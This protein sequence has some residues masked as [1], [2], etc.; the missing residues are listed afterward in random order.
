MNAR[1]RPI[2]P[3]LV[4]LFVWLA[5]VTQWRTL[6][7]P[8]PVAH[9]AQGDLLREV[10]VPA[11]AQCSSGIGTSVAIVPGST[12]NRPQHPILLVVSCYNSQTSSLY[13][14][15]PSTNPAT[16]VLT[17][18]TSPTPTS[19]WGS[20]SFRGDEGDLLGCGNGAT[21]PIYAI[22]IN[23]SNVPAD[24]T[25]TFLF[26]ATA[27]LN[28]CD[29]VAWDTSDNT[30]FQGPDVSNTIY[31]YTAAGASLGSLVSP[32]PYD[33]GQS[34]YKGKSGL[35]V[36]G[37]SLFIACD[38]SLLIYEVNKTTGATITSFNTAGT[39][40]EDLEC[41]PLTFSGE[42]KD[43]IWSR[44]AYTNQLFA[45]EIPLDTCGF[46]G[47]LPGQISLEKTV[48]LDAGTCATGDSLIVSVTT[49]VT[50][51]YRV[52]NTGPL[53]MTTH[54]LVDSKVGT[55]LNDFNYVLA[56]GASTFVT[57]TAVITR[58]TVNTATWT[59]YTADGNPATASD[60]ATVDAYRIF[61][62]LVLGGA[63]I[64]AAAGW[65]RRE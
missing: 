18:T 10:D 21:A 11:G 17:I 47:G 7:Q 56:P 22:D 37:T 16:L 6:W 9:A 26:N 53:T 62:P 57:A 15:A 12:V 59:A 64:T 14:L 43:A 2:L 8:A 36:G 29:G 20:L 44:D 24:G 28:I 45:F 23:P 40:T 46:G 33:H 4:L 5:L 13:F 35:A 55:V 3:W 25:A 48:G 63:A 58:P 61:L 30:V 54:D 51:C 31:H 32:C 65:R 39:R 50:Y 38:G 42:G 60:S 19:G 49:T 41:D 27:D 1:L 34:P 52:T